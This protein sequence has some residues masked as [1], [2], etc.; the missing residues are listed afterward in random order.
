MRAIGGPAQSLYGGLIWTILGSGFPLVVA[1]VS[2][3]YLL[4]RV[5]LSAVGIVGFVWT[6]VAFFSTFEFGLGRALTS[7]LSRTSCHIPERRGLFWSAFLFQIVAAA[8]VG[9]IVVSSGDLLVSRV[10]TSPSDK[11]ETRRIFEL[12]A[13]CAPF[14]MSAPSLRALLDSQRKFKEVALVN[15]AFG[16][17]TYLAP[18]LF[19]LFAHSTYVM[20]QSIVAVR[21]TSWIAMAALAFQNQP[22]LLIP[23]F[24]R[25]T[26]RSLFDFSLWLA[27]AGGVLG[28]LITY[29]DRLIA[30]MFFS[31]ANSAIYVVAFV[32]MSRFYVLSASTYQVLLPTF[33]NEF[34]RDKQTGVRT[35]AQAV[36]AM[37]VL[38]VPTLILIGLFLE[39]LL[40]LAGESLNS[41]DTRLILKALLTGV[42]FNLLASIPRALIESSGKGKVLAQLYAVQLPIYCLALLAAAQYSLVAIAYVWSARVALDALSMFLIALKQLGIRRLAISRNSHAVAVL[43]AAATL[44]SEAMTAHIFVTLLAASI[45]LISLLAILRPGLM[46]PQYFATS[47]GEDC[48]NRQD[49]R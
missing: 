7:L 26:A 9:L 33:A 5:G 43:G 30:A 28:P 19:A 12:L 24:D 40:S 23:R 4:S 18:V 41:R 37:V 2:S 16:S 3:Q 45:T 11:E 35:I 29:A 42:L 20:V 15:L 44:F 6:A 49:G 27:I 1:I 47:R 17:L 10:T 38:A 31:V 13:I 25:R 21:I 32:L 36:N 46:K 34:S 39:P 14:A 22:E 48:V 8:M